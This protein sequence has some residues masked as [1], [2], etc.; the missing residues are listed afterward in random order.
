MDHYELGNGWFSLKIVD[1]DSRMNINTA[2]AMAN[3]NGN[4]DILRQ[5]LTLIGVDAAAH[6]EIISS[7][8]DW[9]DQNN[10]VSNSGAENDYYKTLDPPYFAKNAPIDDLTELLLVKGITPEMYWGSG[11]SGH[12]LQVLNRDYSRVKHSKFEAPTYAI[13]FVDLFTPLS[14]GRINI[15]TASATVLQLIHE[16]DE[17]CANAIISGPGGRIG[18]DGM[19]GTD[20]DGF[21]SVGD[22]A[23]IPCFAAP[24]PAARAGQ[25]PGPAGFDRFFTV[26]SLVFEVQVDAYVGNYHR[27]YIAVLRRNGPRDIQTLSFYWKTS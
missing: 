7:L 25:P 20:D 23:R 6:Q 14:S 21:R 13:G 24:P 4:D 26:R 10:G 16:I 11:V 2:I 8:I 27:K 3:N 5:A 22:L 9:W 17:N 15:N 19:D 18:P 1:N 12:Q